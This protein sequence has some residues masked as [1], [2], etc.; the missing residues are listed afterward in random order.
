[1]S[2]ANYLSLPASEALR[3]F[4][5]LAVFRFAAAQGQH[6]GFDLPPDRLPLQLGPPDGPRT[7]LIIDDQP[8]LREAVGE[9]LAMQGYEV[10]L[11]DSGCEAMQLLEGGL[12][13]DLVLCDVMLPD[14][15]GGSL[16]REARIM[17]PEL[18]MLFISGYPQETVAAKIGE[19]EFL[20]KPFRLDVL[21]R[22]VR[23][24]L[25]SGCLQ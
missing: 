17:F 18:K 12:T 23:G 7:I 10:K 22:R 15:D 16:V 19:E 21:A 8:L 9:Y 24:L 3:W 20:Q 13:P 11:A 6:P 2:A 1:M 14:I 4:K 25:A 5:V